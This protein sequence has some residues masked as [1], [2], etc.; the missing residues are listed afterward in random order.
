MGRASSQCLIY[1]LLIA[2][3]AC[4]KLE[5]AT[6]RCRALG[7]GTE[8]RQIY[9]VPCAFGSGSRRLCEFPGD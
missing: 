9:K 6:P 8:P 4:R 5:Q 3:R 7:S 2:S 1:G